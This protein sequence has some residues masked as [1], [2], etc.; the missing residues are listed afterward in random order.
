MHVNET[1]KIL[2]KVQK[3]DKIQDGAMFTRKFKMAT[4]FVKLYMSIPIHRSIDRSNPLRI[5]G[6]AIFLKIFL[7]PGGEC[8][9]TNSSGGG[10]ICPF[11]IYGNAPP[12]IPVEGDTSVPSKSKWEILRNNLHHLAKLLHAV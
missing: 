4:I 12:Q 10:Y 11:Q 5:G 1:N 6:D 2:K 8:I 7:I 3:T 9:P